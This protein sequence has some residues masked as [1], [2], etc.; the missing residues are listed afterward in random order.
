LAAGWP[1]ANYWTGEVTANPGNAGHN[2][3]LVNLGNG[4]ADNANNL[5]NSNPVVC[6]P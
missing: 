3:R 6:R 5:D 2:A 1:V 4:N